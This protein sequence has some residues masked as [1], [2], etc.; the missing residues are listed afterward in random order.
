MDCITQ[1]KQGNG[2]AVQD[3]NVG[4]P[5]ARELP[6]L[7]LDFPAA[8][9]GT[10]AGEKSSGYMPGTST[11]KNPSTLM[12]MWLCFISEANCGYPKATN[13]RL[14][15]DLALESRSHH[16]TTSLIIVHGKLSAFGKSR[17]AEDFLLIKSKLMN[18]SILLNLVTFVI[19]KRCRLD[20]V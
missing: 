5:V 7:S 6:T 11:A 2:W 14:L 20:I 17:A 19:M 10:P 9:S 18:G 13:I 4:K 3:R 8:A 1:G 16:L 15:R 12:M